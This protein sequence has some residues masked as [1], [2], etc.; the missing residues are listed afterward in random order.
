MKKVFIAVS[1][2]FYKTNLFNELCKKEDI[3]VVYTGSY[4]KSTRNA[5]FL[6]GDKHFNHINIEGSKGLRLIRLIRLL[7]SE[8]Y[9]EVIIGGYDN[10]FCWIPLFLVNK[11]KCSL[12]VESTFRET[13]KHGFRFFLKRVF[14]SRISRVY[15]PGSPHAQ[16]VKDLGFKGEIRLWNSVGLINAIPQP[17]FSKRESVHRFL[18]VGRFIPEKNLPWLISVFKKHPE[19][20]LTIVGFGAQESFLKALADVDNIVFTGPV[21]NNDLPSY[22]QDADVFILPSR[23][24]TWGLVIEESLNNGTPVMCSH[25]VGCADDL[26]IAKKTGVVFRLDDEDDF[27]HKL[28]FICNVENYNMFRKMVSLMDFDLHERTIVNAFVG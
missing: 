7:F 23:T 22:Y 25:M 4:D 27:E 26:V 28:S 15:A 12:I 17:P 21:N 24:E 13:V 1:P 2:G 6:R 10:L 3:L 18:F 14:I 5:D 19:L 11:K 16:L 20:Q 8:K 9:K